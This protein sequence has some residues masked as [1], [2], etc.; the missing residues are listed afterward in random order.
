[1]KTVGQ[2]LQERPHK[3]PETVHRQ[4]LAHVLKRNTAWLIAHDDVTVINQQARQIKDYQRQFIDGIP[5]AYILGEQ[6]FWDLT[7]KVNEHTLIPRP[8]TELIIETILDLNLSP[9][10]ILDLGTGSGALALVLARLFPNASVTATDISSQAI[11]VAQSNAQ[12]YHIN[13]ICFIQS[14]WFNNIQ[15]TF[16]LIVSNPPYI[17][18]DDSHLSGLTHEPITALVADNNGLAD[19][20]T[21]I[22]LAPQFLNHNGILLVEHGYN[23]QQ[24]VAELF[25]DK[26][27]CKIKTLFDIEQRP[28]ATMGYCK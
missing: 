19:L 22:R 2:W 28:R 6:A 23:Q 3:I 1:M 26:H 18:P 16:D 4:L 5:L 21:I 14:H 11:T 25:T 27:Y 24:T 13:N 9:S 8:D 17:E 20:Q 15:G 12:K 10:S 7:L